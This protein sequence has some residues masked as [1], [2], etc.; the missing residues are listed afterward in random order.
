MKKIKFQ[1]E[2]CK[3]GYTM[4]A[5]C[6]Y[7]RTTGINPLSDDQRNQSLENLL[8]MAYC[9][10]VTT[11]SEKDYPALDDVL[12]Q[13]TAEEMTDLL[14]AAADERAAYYLPLAGEKKDDKKEEE[15]K[16]NL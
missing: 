15:D 16:K 7:E 5:A 2:E 4:M 12:L 1:G 10:L 8:T 6:L 13:L 3:I 14:H 9:Q 11:E